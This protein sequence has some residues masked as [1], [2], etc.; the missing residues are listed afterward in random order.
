[1]DFHGS[2]RAAVLCPVKYRKAQADKRRIK[3]FQ[4]FVLYAEL[5]CAALYLPGKMAEQE[6]VII[7]EQFPVSGF[8]QI[9][10]ARFCYGPANANVVQ[11]TRGRTQPVAD[12]AQRACSGKLHEQHADK[13]RPGVYPLAVLIAF[14]TAYT[15]FKNFFGKAF[16]YL[17]K[18]AYIHHG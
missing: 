1:M 15:G 9:A 17:R 6:I 13:V 8:I 12:I 2:F 5:F 3:Y 16:D 18:Q 11:V 14:M 7:P 4:L 10:Q